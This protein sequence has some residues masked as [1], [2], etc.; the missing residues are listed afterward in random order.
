[1]TQDS[2][3]AAYRWVIVFA[4]ALILAISMGAI[5]NGMSAFIVPMQ[6][7]FGWSR[8]D[9]ALI[10]FAGI[11]GLAF[12]GVVAGRIADRIGVRPVLLFGVVVLGLCY[13][14]ASF[15]TS[16]WQF[17]A[18]FVVAGFFG[19]GAVFAP[20]VAL[21]G[22]WFAAGAGLALGIVSAGQALGQGGVPFGSSFLIESYGVQGALGITGAIMLAVMTP[23]VLL[24]RPAPA[25]NGVRSASGSDAA[26]PAIPYNVVVVRMSAAV[27]LCC[28]CMSVPLM[29]LV[30][31]IQDVGFPPEV[32]SSVIFAMMLSAIL[33]RV[34]FG[35][36]ADMIGA[37]PS[38]MTATAWMTAMVFGFVWLNRLDVFYVY[39]IVYGFGYAGVMTGILTSVSVLTPAERRASAMGIVTMFAFFGHAIGGYLGGLLYDLTGA[40]DAPYAVAAG[41]GILNLIIVNTLLR[42]TRRPDLVAA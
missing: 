21:V 18:L 20:V 23:L 25:R 7:R 35:R 1:M 12:G 26:E 13:L 32:A 41:A 17:Y 31:L 3:Q 24:M 39:A 10:N 27:I 14:V 40:Y 2:P 33:G 16:L 37:V 30:P 42:R 22:K 11:M 8:G 19:A 6:E 34:A 15:L 36:L 9:A 29:H 38:Y 4:A 28:T 5:V